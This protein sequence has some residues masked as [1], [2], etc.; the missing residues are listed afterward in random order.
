MAVTVDLANGHT[1]TVN[2][3]NPRAT[4]AGS[5]PRFTRSRVNEAYVV[6]RTPGP[7][8]R[9]R[10]A[11]GTPPARPDH[12]PS[13]T[14]R[15]RGSSGPPTRP[16][17][18]VPVPP[19]NTRRQR[20]TPFGPH[21]THSCSLIRNGCSSGRKTFVGRTEKTG[22]RPHRRCFSGNRRCGGSGRPPRSARGI[23]KLFGNACG[24]VDVSG[25]AGERWWLTASFKPLRR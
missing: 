8:S 20:P 13:T 15:R 17:R 19:D 22:C 21:R 11:A 14:P 9:Q 4:F 6:S 12:Q 3:S 5:P 25:P 1:G 10:T 7:R 24:A 18:G 16:P 2:L 23:V